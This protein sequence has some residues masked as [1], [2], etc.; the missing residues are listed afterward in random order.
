MS[1]L[2]PRDGIV[3][4]PH[5]LPSGANPANSSP[6]EEERRRFVPAVPQVLLSGEFEVVKGEK[7][8]ALGQADAIAERFPQVYGQPFVDLVPA[9]KATP[10]VPPTVPGEPVA[11]IRQPSK[12]VAL[13]IGCVLSG[14]QAAGGSADGGQVRAAA[15]SRPCA[16]ES[17]RL[18]R[19][20]AILLRRAA[21]R[22]SQEHLQ[23]LVQAAVPR[24]GQRGR[25]CGQMLGRRCV[26]A[27]RLRQRQRAAELSALGHLHSAKNCQ[28][29]LGR[30]PAPRHPR[31]MRVPG[32]A[33]AELLANR[34][35]Q[36][37]IAKASASLRR[38]SLTRE[39]GDTD[40]SA[41]S[42]PD[43]STLLTER[44]PS[45]FGLGGSTV[46]NRSSSA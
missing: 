34:S 15:A 45:L 29:W 23:R 9:S 17:A 43:T 31:P 35:C 32:A 38:R 22:R 30:L 37:G 14:G 39:P 24:G 33:T 19:R 10:G 1:T 21:H 41:S 12:L 44:L 11:V 42:L 5:A 27:V 8:T 46:T 6:L 28:R 4:S 2:N 7:T 25:V 3:A 18:S 20:S 16:G 13:R 36:S 40:S 26:R